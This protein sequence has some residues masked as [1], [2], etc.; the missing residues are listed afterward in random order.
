ME[1]HSLLQLFDVIKTKE[2]VDLTHAFDRNIPHW[3]GYPEEEIKTIFYH[4]EGVGSLGHGF[5]AQQINIVTQWGT[6]IDTPNHFHR[7]ARSLDQIN[8]KELLCPLAV[9]DIHEHVEK[10][11]DYVVTLADLEAWEKKHG[12]IPKEAFVALRTDWSKRWPDKDQFKNVGT[13]GVPHS[14]GWS[15]EV[16][17]FL[18]EERHVTAVGHETTDT[19]PGFLSSKGDFRGESYVLEKDIYQIE[20]LTNL[21][22]IP[23]WGALIIVGFPKAKGAP[24]FPVRA[25]A[26]LP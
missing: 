7:G 12:S 24:G 19:D 3:P 23:E 8:V 17:K 6:H 11:P 1:N 9:L 5:F 20:M 16:L 2:F 14:P 13:D 10:N 18:C 25:Y 15:M 21:D 22:K 4:D 26:I